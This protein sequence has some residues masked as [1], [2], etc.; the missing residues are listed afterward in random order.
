M[1]PRGVSA[2]RAQLWVRLRADDP[3]A[4][5]ALAVA[6]TMDGGEGAPASVRRFRLLELRGVLPP[7]GELEGLLGRSIQ[8]YN[9]QKESAALRLA[10]ADAAPLEPG[11]RAVLVIERGGVR[12]RAAERW[13]RAATGHAVEVREG[14]VWAL[15][16]PPGTDGARAAARL[17]VVRDR[18]R[19]LFC[20]PHAE[21]H[22]LAGATAPFPW[23]SRARGGQGR[24]A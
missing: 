7:R 23:L 5:S 14:V 18:R 17:A 2:G 10:A 1:S 22:R 6:R 21:R 16:F 3:E 8:F 20:N 15:R 12:R 19:G 4:V 9:P 13:W 11:E 24:D